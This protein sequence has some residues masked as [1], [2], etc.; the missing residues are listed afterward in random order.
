MTREWNNLIA[1]ASDEMLEELH[2]SIRYQLKMRK[3]FATLSQ[4]EVSGSLDKLYN[5]EL[6][7]LYIPKDDIIND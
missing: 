6:A 4:T 5:A 1:S 3:M 2:R 7:K